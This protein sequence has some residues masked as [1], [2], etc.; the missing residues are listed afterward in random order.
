M[1]TNKDKLMEGV[2]FLALGFPFIF[3]GPALMTWL[4][5]PAYRQGNYIWIGVSI[6]LMLT[7]AF[8][9]IRGLRTVLSAF[10]DAEDEPATKEKESNPKV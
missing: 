9:C 1:A 5:I 10:F 3:M 7:A 2:R 4:G 8:L 6:L